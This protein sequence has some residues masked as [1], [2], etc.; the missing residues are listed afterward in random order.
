MRKII[1]TLCIAVALLSCSNT[2]NSKQQTKQLEELELD[3]DPSIDSLI[4]HVHIGNN[5]EINA[6]ELGKVSYQEFID[7]GIEER[8]KSLYLNMLT[9]DTSFYKFKNQHITLFFPIE[10]EDE[11]EDEIFFYSYE[12]NL[13]G[14]NITFANGLKPFSTRQEVIE[15][16]QKLGIEITNLGFY[17]NVLTF[18]TEEYMVEL[19]L[20]KISE[21]EGNFCEIK[22]SR[23]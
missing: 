7:L 11:P 10:D 20:D 21:T 5:W 14:Q 19:H 18:Y 9:S 6:W 12:V 3:V 1:Y 17:S 8:F 23:K 16:L 4:S 13:K 2:T 15:H 22:V